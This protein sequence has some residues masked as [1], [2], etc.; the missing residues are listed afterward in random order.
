MLIFIDQPLNVG[1]SYTDTDTMV[2]TTKQ[3]SL[4]MMNFYDNFFKYYSNMTDNPLFFFGES[5]AGHYSII[6]KDFIIQYFL[7]FLY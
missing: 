3:A 4:H 5:Y 7:L 6:I 2:N 1:L